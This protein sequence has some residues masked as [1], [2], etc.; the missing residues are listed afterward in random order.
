MVSILL[1][2]WAYYKINSYSN[3]Q[4]KWIIN[5]VKWVALG[6]FF[7]TMPIPLI[8]FPESDRFFGIYLIALTYVGKYVMEKISKKL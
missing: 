5:S 2:I 7:L 8:F 3:D 1:G 6:I 4:P